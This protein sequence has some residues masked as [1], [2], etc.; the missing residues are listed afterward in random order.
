MKIE[1]TSYQGESLEKDFLYRIKSN[2][3]DACI[4]GGEINDI[5]IQGY[6]ASNNQQYARYLLTSIS[7]FAFNIKRRTGYE[8]TCY[9]PD[10]IYEQR[11][12][13]TL[14]S[15]LLLCQ[16]L[17]D[18]QF[19]EAV[20]DL[21]KAQKHVVSMLQK[22]NLINEDGTVSV[23]RSLNNAEL[24]QII[25]D[26]TNGS[27]DNPE[28]RY[29]IQTNILL[30]AERE[31]KD[32]D[33][34]YAHKEMKV[35]F[36]INIEDILLHPNFISTSY[37]KKRRVYSSLCNEEE[38]LFLN[39]HPKGWLSFKTSDIYSINKQQ[40]D[41]WIKYIKEERSKHEHE[42]NSRVDDLSI[43]LTHVTSDEYY[44]MMDTKVISFHSRLNKLLDNLSPLLRMMVKRQIKKNK[45]Y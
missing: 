3:L 28:Y 19:Y 38:I 8:E 32:L 11:S 6:T 29:T 13:W 37:S 34:G 5:E 2:V 9:L 7:K 16:S 36:H 40:I 39:R 23:Y 44:L 20:L 26:F 18:E 27:L 35:C 1:N 4:E 10:T 21:Q 25:D 24:A 42:R 12:M 14:D 22:N 15:I 30:S 17:S 45:F 43:D 33:K 31:H 41:S